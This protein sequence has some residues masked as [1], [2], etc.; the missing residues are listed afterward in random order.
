MIASKGC[1]EPS[2]ENN[3]A[4]IMVMVPRVRIVA[5]AVKALSLSILSACLS[6]RRNC[7]MEVTREAG[8]ELKWR[9]RRFRFPD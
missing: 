5:Y 7:L 8:L 9:L 3:A 6:V 2:W 4:V 1:N